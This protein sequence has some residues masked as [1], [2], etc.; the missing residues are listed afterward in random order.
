MVDEAILDIAMDHGP[1]SKLEDLQGHLRSR[2]I[3][4]FQSDVQMLVWSLISRENLVLSRE[5]A[6]T[7]KLHKHGKMPDKKCDPA[8]L[9]LGTPIAWIW[10]VEKTDI[11]AWVRALR[12]WTESALID[13]HYVGGRA[14]VLAILYDRS[15]DVFTDG[16]RRLAPVLSITAV[17]GEDPALCRAHAVS[18]LWRTDLQ[19]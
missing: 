6:L 17:P 15:F 9:E 1:I 19:K 16:C 10:G 18:T 7:F 14:K 3:E 13:W 11:D 12:G 2:G 5:F 4:V 8:V